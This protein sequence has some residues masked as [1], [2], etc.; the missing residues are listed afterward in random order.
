M[1]GCG[2]TGLAGNGILP[3]LMG[4]WRVYAAF[5]C[6]ALTR[7]HLALAAA[8]ILFRPSAD[9]LRVCEIDVAVLAVAVDCGPLRS[10]AHLAL[11]ASAILLRAD[12]DMV[13]FGRVP[14][15]LDTEE[16]P[17]IPSIAKIAFPS[18]STSD[19]AFLCPSRS[20]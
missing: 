16:D 13:L 6:W 4:S 19:C 9:N 3:A 18:P 17:V 14:F 2:N 11:W 8:A 12:A 5:F 15:G 20:C 7:A 10:F 1:N